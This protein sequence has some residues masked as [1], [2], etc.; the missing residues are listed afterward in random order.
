MSSRSVRKYVSRPTNGITCDEPRENEMKIRHRAIDQWLGIWLSLAISI[1]LV[2]VGCSAPADGVSGTDVEDEDVGAD[3]SDDPDAGGDADAAG[4]A[5]TRDTDPRASDVPG[6]DD[7]CDRLD[8]CEASVDNCSSICHATVDGWGDEAID[9]FVACFTDD[10]TCDELRDSDNPPQMCYSEIPLDEERSDRC[11][12]FT[13][14]LTAECGLSSPESDEFDAD[15]RGFA[16]TVSDEDWQ[17]TDN[18]VD[19]ADDGNCSDLADCLND[20]LELDPQL[21]ID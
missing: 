18:C 12:D 6:C 21:D 9:D 8:E 20:A 11:E 3:D 13:E 19:D 16:R 1:P 7:I 5:D 2:F 15:C 17:E 14:A 4:D 10:K